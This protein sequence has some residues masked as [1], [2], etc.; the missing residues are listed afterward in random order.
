[1]QYHF[2]LVIDEQISSYDIMIKRIS[3]ANEACQRVQHVEGIEPITAVALVSTIG[4]PSAFENCCHFAA[5]IGLAPKQY[6]RF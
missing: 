5:F 2:L 1:M 3:K 4:D 6:S